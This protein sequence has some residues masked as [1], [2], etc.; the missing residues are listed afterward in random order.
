MPLK[1]GQGR[2]RVFGGDH[3]VAVQ[4]KH[5]GQQLAS[6]EVAFRDEYFHVIPLVSGG[7]K[8]LLSLPGRAALLSLGALNRAVTKIG[9]AGQQNYGSKVKNL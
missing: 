1:H 6:R 5:L 9:P 8:L 3:L 4:L 7:P 2:R